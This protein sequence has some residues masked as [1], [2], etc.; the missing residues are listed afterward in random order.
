MAIW[1]RRKLKLL[2]DN[3]LTNKRLKM[4]NLP[5]INSVVKVIKALT[6]KDPRLG[7]TG[8]VIQ[9][10]A[11]G[12]VCVHFPDMPPGEGIFFNAYHLEIIES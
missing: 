3:K 8:T 11:H 6:E 7:Q 10:S 2:I 5:P 9:Y 1:Y 4:S 12:M